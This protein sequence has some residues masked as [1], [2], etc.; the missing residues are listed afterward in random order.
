MSANTTN[1]F[2]SLLAS[3]KFGIKKSTNRSDNGDDYTQH[4]SPT[5]KA[6]R[7]ALSL[8]FSTSEHS[9]I[10]E[11]LIEFQQLENEAKKQRHGILARKRSVPKRT[12]SVYNS[13]EM[14][15]NA[16]MVGNVE[17]TRQ[18][19]I[20]EKVDINSFSHQGW[21]ALHFACRQGNTKMI[22]LLL[23][24]GANT[25][26]LNDNGMTPLLVAVTHG[27]F[28]AAACLIN[29]GGASCDEIKN[30]FQTQT[31][32]KDNSNNNR[33]NKLKVTRSLESRSYDFT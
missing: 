9:L 32:Y 17:L 1:S 18:V 30:G 27:N 33:H 15:H 5:T 19:L 23:D 4:A 31:S 13:D 28:D 26:L 21:T 6:R 8:D 16:V 22:K 20:N 25:K 24:N 3:I 7:Q 12:S 11:E 10:L 29:D 14:L 2:S